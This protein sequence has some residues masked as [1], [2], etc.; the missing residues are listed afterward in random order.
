MTFTDVLDSK[1]SEERVGFMR[2]SVKVPPDIPLATWPGFMHIELTLAAAL[3]LLS[4]SSGSSDSLLS[5]RDNTCTHGRN[6]SPSS[7]S[8][9]ILLSPD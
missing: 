5:G 7:G 1:G 2:I 9:G 6:E 3:P 4:F 8:W